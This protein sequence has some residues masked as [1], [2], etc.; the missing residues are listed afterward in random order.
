MKETDYNDMSGNQ[1]DSARQTAANRRVRQREYW[2]RQFSA[3][4][5]NSSFPTTTNAGKP[6]SMKE[7]FSIEGSLL[8]SLL[9]ISQGN[10]ILLH[11]VLTAALAVLL[12]RVTGRSVVT[13]A[14][15]V[16]KPE[17]GE[18]C[19][20]SILPLRIEYHDT[21]SFKEFL[22]H[23]RQVLLEADENR[24]YPLDLLP[25]FPQF[26]VSILLTT[27]HSKRPPGPNA[28][29]VHFQWTRT[30]ENLEADALFDSA[31]YDSPS[32]R[33][34]IDCYRLVLEQGA[35]DLDIPLAK[36]DVV[37]PGEKERLLGE[38]NGET[39]AVPTDLSVLAMIR[40][41]AARAPQAPALTG[42]LQKE[43][44]EAPDGPATLTYEELL[45][46]A[47]ML[48]QRIWDHGGKNSA[49]VGLLA[50]RSVP[51]IVGMLGIMMAGC[52][53]LPLD[54]EFPPQRLE[55]ML[56][57]SGAALL[58]ATTDA[59][60]PEGFEGEVLLVDAEPED[61]ALPCQSIDA[62]CV[63]PH[64]AA[65]VIYTSGSTG[66]P[67]GVVIEQRQLVNY[68]L[69]LEQAVD[70][71]GCV[72]YATVS[73]ISADLGNTVIYRSLSDGGC[74]H[75]IG[76]A[77]VMDGRRMGDYFLQHGI[78]CLK[79]TPPHL[80]ALQG[81][82]NQPFAPR[83]VLIL[84]G[85][86]ADNVWL[87]RLRTRHPHLRIYNHYG[88]S[89]ATIGVTVHPL[90]PVGTLP[91][92]IP[93]GKPF[94]NAGIYILDRRGNPVPIGVPGE[95]CVGG[96]GLG[97][98]YLNRQAMTAD[99]FVNNINKSLG[100]LYHTGDRA[101]FLEDGNIEFLGRIDRQVKIRGY[102]AE[103][104]EAALQ[105]KKIPGVQDA[106]VTVA[107]E[108]SGDYCLAAYVVL[109]PD[110]CPEIDGL[111]RYPLPNG[112]RVAHV[113]KNETDYIYREIFELQAYGKYGITFEGEGCILDVGANIG[114]FTL[115]VTTVAPDAGIHVF[116]PNPHVRKRLAANIQLYS[117][118]TRVHACGLSAAPGEAEFTFFEGFSLLSG[119]YADAATEKEVVKNYM[120]NQEDAGV[121]GMDEL[122]ASADQVLDHRFS[123]KTFSVQL[124]TLSNVM[125]LENIQRVNLL[126]INVEKAELDVLR[127]V[128][129]GDWQKIRQVVVEVDV[130]EN[131][132]TITGILEENGFECRVEQDMLL[133][134]TPLCYVY[135]IRPGEGR[136]L[137]PDAKDTV[138]RLPPFEDRLLTVDNIRDELK[139][140]L[141]PFM[142]PSYIIPLDRLPL[143]ANGKLDSNALPDP[144]T[145]VS[146]PKREYIAPRTVEETVLQQVWHEV[147]GR[148]PIGI[149][150]NYFMNGGD[151]IKSIQV[152]SRLNRE[153]Y[154][155]EMK[156]IFKNPTI[157]CL[158]PLLRKSER[159]A[160]QAPV[161]G[162]VLLTPVQAEF[163]KRYGP[164]S[165]H[166]NQSVM[167]RSDEPLDKDEI[168]A[169]FSRLLEHH[170][171]L[172][173]VFRFED[174][175]VVQENSGS[176]E[177]SLELDVRDLSQA[178]DGEAMLLHYSDRLQA[179]FDLE[180]GPLLKLGL[181]RFGGS[182]R[183]LIVIHHLVTDGVSWRILFED[184][185]QLFSQ[186]REGK[187]LTLPAK[188][189]SFQC[190]A[191]S[192]HTYSFER[193]LI[194]E[195]PYWREVTAGAG[196]SFSLPRDFAAGSNRVRDAASVSFA[197][198]EGDTRLLL[199]TA[200][201]AFGTETQDIAADIDVSRTVGWFTSTYPVAF[202]IPAGA[203]LGIQV[204][205]VKETLRAVP[206]R[207]VGYG[208][209][210]H[211]TPKELLEDQDLNVQS[212]MIFNYLGQFDTDVSK[213]PFAIAS[214]TAGSERYRDGERSYDWNISAMV[215]G[216]RLEFSIVYSSRQYKEETIQAALAAVERQLKR[217]ISFCAAK[218][219]RRFSPS[220]F[221]YKDLS[222]E[223]LDRL[224]GRYR[225]QDIYRLSPTQQ[226]ML[227]HALYD[228]DSTLYQ[229]QI[230]FRLLGRLDPALVEKSFQALFHRYDVLRTV[231]VHE[232]VSQPLQVVLERQPADFSFIDMS[233]L[234]AEA[235]RTGE[236]ERLKKEDLLK[237]YDLS[238][239]PLMRLSVL[240]L[241]PEE[242]YFIWNHHHIV[243]DGWCAGILITDFFELYNSLRDNQPA[244]LAEP[245]P[246]RV[247]IQWLEGRDK[248]RSR[249]FWN[250][251]LEL[252]REPVGLPKKE[253][254]TKRQAGYRVD[255][256]VCSLDP[257]D[258]LELQQ[259][260][261]RQGVTLNIVI[262]AIWALVLAAFSG[263]RD[264]VFGAVV[265]GRPAEIE[266]IETMVGLFINAI[267]V[268]VRI[269]SGATF[270][271][272]IKQLQERA[273]QCEPHHH[274][275]LADIQGG[276]PLRQ[277]LLDHVMGFE[278]YPMSSQLDRATARNRRDDIG[279]QLTLMD[280]DVLVES[281]YD[282][283]V[284]VH[285]GE[286]VT[287]QLEFNA[288]V[289]DVET[290]NQVAKRLKQ[291]ARFILLD[292]ESF[293]DDCLS[294][295]DDGLEKKLEDATI[296]LAGET[297]L[298]DDGDF[299]F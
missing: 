111:Q 150:D 281:S 241:G 217:L 37:S 222:A 246:Y 297:H 249:L 84:G 231:Y 80:A 22:T 24:D 181:Y 123:A 154:R 165:H 178:S 167:L 31:G 3:E 243:M 245:K 260:A 219:E 102:R 49:I 286:T 163:F 207:G 193:E 234:T 270:S 11:I 197:L 292:S 285:T 97:R 176:E 232:G 158:A 36:I 235:V 251:Y 5:R 50:N 126:K 268:R 221:T 120:I 57:D 33:R 216:G 296:L 55:F 248:E 155:I 133:E 1:L 99:R 52:A 280:L 117:P 252:Y 114:L 294:R 14:V 141:P 185:A 23:V 177:V 45:G 199:T 54:G 279:Q 225:V 93:I 142:V 8:Q 143:N 293:L 266:G 74:L 4:W 106:V 190:W 98:G 170:D 21:L 115:F 192:L 145:F 258:S 261:S 157:A 71:C 65:Y 46:Q 29:S 53:Y 94:A 169:V 171:A 287:V 26:D 166:F 95:L 269:D 70:F 223:Q 238:H 47:S 184:M 276:H 16:Y 206:N 85:E 92:N 107:R 186:Y 76:D 200:H 136:K 275:P 7:E 131:L 60:V 205:H 204:T 240:R 153:G 227:Y 62:G 195:I 295:V 132:D 215:A 298:D 125:R 68:L 73:T 189:D 175:A 28:R 2:T 43:D 282:L 290:L 211:I 63:P 299:D 174:G 101:R 233:S 272:L 144:F 130:M 78:D 244:R 277:T 151:S 127:G 239:D 39:V 59:V 82:G 242:Y 288:N 138:R 75:I 259:L 103:P 247:Y 203:D 18:E 255:K 164:G 198:E 20:N 180:T 159:V 212:P 87:E 168:L 224:S 35:D 96:P 146:D 119:L 194:D 58:L 149:H 209:L 32:M 208:A 152:A 160:D 13:L 12:E 218:K 253:S 140:V 38:F 122:V 27:I 90:P 15:P 105:L 110:V 109:E 162:R 88:P 267:P 148:S 64:H 284:V 256:V 291:L 273:L 108:K 9:S 262:Q 156:D 77:T 134:G 271:S 254:Q 237:A 135:A 230:S 188:S 202:E 118:G 147:L 56:K 265:S 250:R 121:E 25:G 83:Q 51:V 213:L 210:A 100:R 72:H 129:E 289:Y 201:N 116:E 6:G 257:A 66:T 191:Q 220:D 124:D 173:M 187:P 86:A 104:G 228:E 179:S 91:A 69:G 226:G 137:D 40:D 89:E 112:L 41:A 264:V 183:L 161:K 42:Y 274:Y 263:K 30:G 44:S 19:I 34:F 128:E 196:E 236:V 81:S 172:R 10:D 214:E 79:I 67:K 283:S 182:D 139:A 278:N 48:A 61:G 229:G 113:N 17:K